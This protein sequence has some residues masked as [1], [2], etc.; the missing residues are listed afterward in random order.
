MK[1]RKGQMFV[2]DTLKIID[3]EKKNKKYLCTTKNGSVLWV[4]EE[5]L[6]LLDLL[7]C[8][9]KFNNDMYLHIKYSNDGE[10]FTSNNG[11]TPGIWIGTCISSD[12]SEEQLK[13]SDFHWENILY[14]HLQNEKGGLYER[15]K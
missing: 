4:S 12:R 3:I 1:Y 8:S 2:L 13:F 14:L 6:N 5:D 10:T 9:N 15:F 11:E 7:P